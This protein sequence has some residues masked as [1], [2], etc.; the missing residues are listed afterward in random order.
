MAYIKLTNQ[1]LKFVLAEFKFSP[2]LKMEDFIPSLQEEFRKKYPIFNKKLDRTIRL[3]Q[4]NVETED[5]GRWHFVSGEKNHAIEIDRERIIYFT[6]HYD[7]FDGFANICEEI[8]NVLHKIA[9]PYSIQRVGL[10]Y[11]NLIIVKDNEKIEDLVHKHFICPSDIAELGLNKQQKTEVLLNTNA[12]MLAIRAFYGVNALSHFPDLHGRLPITIEAENS[13]N[14]R[15]VLDID[16]FWE[17]STD[18]PVIFDSNSIMCQL[19][20]LHEIAIAAF[21]RT[22]T[23][24]ARSTIWK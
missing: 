20:D 23:E 7:R 16:H 15:V 13:T 10:R 2:I 5:I 8:L 19:T 14:E 6:S 9:E 17:S 11:S 21:W 22:T 1:P 3:Y 4:N 24:Y 18:S 12:G